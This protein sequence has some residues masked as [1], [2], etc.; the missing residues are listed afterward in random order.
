[1]R[2]GRREALRW[3]AASHDIVPSSTV[4]RRAVHD[5]VGGYDPQ[6]LC[7]DFEY[8]LRVALISDI[9]FLAEPLV[10]VRVHEDSATSTMDPGR[11]VVELD[12]L[13]PRLRRH[14]ED[15]GVRP[16][17]GWEAALRSLRRRF[18]RRLLVAAATALTRGQRELFRGYCDAARKLD[19]APATRLAA[20]GLGILLHGPGPALLRGVRAGRHWFRA[21][22]RP[23][24][25]AGSPGAGGG[26]ASTPRG[27]TPA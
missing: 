21:R 6:L 7:A 2:D 26:P 12:A 13:A 11:W 9:A 17:Q 20:G 25:L 19:D 14:C 10:W 23:G 22:R 15:A 4:V 3:L 27:S 8:Y 16:A 5:R 1:V 24:S 18:A